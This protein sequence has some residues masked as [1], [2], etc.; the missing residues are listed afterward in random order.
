MIWCAEVT[1]LLV[2]TAI[3][4]PDPVFATLYGANGPSPLP[5][6]YGERVVGTAHS[7]LVQGHGP[8]PGG[9][10]AKSRRQARG[11]G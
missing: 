6:E 4:T 10:E 11:R 8:A 3:E 5:W 1:Q 9:I 2:S 7:L